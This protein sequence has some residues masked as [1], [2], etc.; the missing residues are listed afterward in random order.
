MISTFSSTS[1]APSATAVAIATESGVAASVTWSVRSSCH[2]LKPMNPAIST[3]M[4]AVP[5]RKDL[6]VIRETTS[7]RVTSSQA[8]SVLLSVLFSALGAHAVAS[9]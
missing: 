6:S 7:R 2:A 8:G 1:G 3:T 4:N 9:R 5:R